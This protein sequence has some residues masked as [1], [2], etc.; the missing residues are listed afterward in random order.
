MTRRSTKDNRGLRRPTIPVAYL[1]HLLTV[2]AERGIDARDARAGTGL[3]D[4][5]LGEPD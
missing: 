2:F 4:D 1:R 5:V 3:R